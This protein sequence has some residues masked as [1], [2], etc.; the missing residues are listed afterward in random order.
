[1]LLNES[2]DVRLL[3]CFKTIFRWFFYLKIQQWQLILL[4][5]FLITVACSSTSCSLKIY[6]VVGLSGTTNRNRSDAFLFKIGRGNYV[7]FAIFFFSIKSDRGKL[8]D[9]HNSTSKRW[10]LLVLY[11]RSQSLARF[12]PCKQKLL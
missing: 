5:T 2:P 11:L 10:F 7:M 4:P 8:H 3:S 9:R 6:S 12:M 1:M